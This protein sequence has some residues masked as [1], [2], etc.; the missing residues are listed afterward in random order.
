MKKRFIVVYGSSNFTDYPLFIKAM[1]EILPFI[2][3]NTVFM[4]SYGK[5]AQGMIADWCETRDIPCAI[6]NASYDKYGKDKSDV[7]MG[8]M[9]KY[10]VD[11]VVTF[12]TAR[13]KSMKPLID[14]AREKGI[15]VYSL[16]EGGPKPKDK[17]VNI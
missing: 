15:D 7:L 11:L 14:R 17:G 6:L 16:T 13:G 8:W 2:D 1:S 10:P 3:D 12:S 4:T 5:G 9:V